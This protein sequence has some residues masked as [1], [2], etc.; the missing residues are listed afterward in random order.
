M[1]TKGVRLTHTSRDWPGDWEEFGL[2][3]DLFK[4]I[5]VKT[6]KIKKLEQP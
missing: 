3:F 5:K 2:V 1:R 6:G 4:M